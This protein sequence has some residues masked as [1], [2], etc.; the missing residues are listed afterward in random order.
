LIIYYPYPHL[1]ACF[2]SPF[3]KHF[4]QRKSCSNA[5]FVGIRGFCETKPQTK[6]KSI[7]DAILAT[8]E[9]RP[10]KQDKELDLAKI[11]PHK[12]KPAEP[13]KK[14]TPPLGPPELGVSDLK[15]VHLYPRLVRRWILDAKTPKGFYDQDGTWKE[16]SFFN[17]LLE[18]EDAEEF[19][20]RKTSEGPYYSGRTL[21]PP[22]TETSRFVE[23]ENLPEDLRGHYRFDIQPEEMEHASPKLKELLSIQ[24]AGKA[25]LSRFRRR[26]ATRQYGRKPHDTGSS[27]VQVVIFT[28]QIRSLSDHLRVNS[29]DKPARRGLEMLV[30]RRR[31]MMLY[32][33][34]E[35]PERYWKILKQ[36]NLRDALPYVPIKKK[37]TALQQ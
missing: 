11:F 13:S 16:A 30:A 4:P 10:E 8:F 34:N 1:F 33:K 25:E 31:R 15:Y 37:P 19:F 36:Y 18:D 28:H 26:Q 3:F 21:I 24:N 27:A 6:G 7:I 35:D 2:S 32:L 12:P 22:G 20:G 23:Y 9:E 5:T 29:K 17:S 14:D